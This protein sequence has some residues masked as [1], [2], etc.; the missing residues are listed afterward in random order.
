MNSRMDKTADVHLTIPC[1]RYSSQ[2]YQVQREYASAGEEPTFGLHFAFPDFGLVLAAI[3]DWSLGVNLPVGEGRRQVF[4]L[5]RDEDD[6]L[7]G[8][9]N[10]RGLTTEYFVRFGGNI[11]YSVRPSER[12]KG[13]ASRMLALAIDH[14]REAGLQ[15]ILV[16][17][18][19]DNLA[20]RRA[21][22][23]NGGILEGEVADRDGERYLRF[24]V[25]TM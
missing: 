16:T 20:S 4:W 13:Y 23:D 25:S 9:V 2:Y 14:C 6:R 17:C 22:T 18:H 11:G 15:R 8:T 7:L 1:E 5:I 21:I 24:W 10:I 3:R 19:P 12:R